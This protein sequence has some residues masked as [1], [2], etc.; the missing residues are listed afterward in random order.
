[1]MT[2]REFEGYLDTHS[3]AGLDLAFLIA[4]DVWLEELIN[5]LARIE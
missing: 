4:F 2:L 3:E 5:I 1:M